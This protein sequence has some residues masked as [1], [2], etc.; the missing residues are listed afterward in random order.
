MSSITK[1]P[2]SGASP[3]LR[4]G[5]T[6]APSGDWQDEYLARLR[7]VIM[8]ADPAIVEEWK[9]KKPSNPEGV[10]VWYHDGIV[11]VGNTLKNAVRLTFPNGPEL[12]DPAKLFNTRLDSKVVRA[13]D[14]FEDAKLN[15][16]ALR[17]LVRAAVR[18]NASLVR[19]REA[20]SKASKG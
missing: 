13:I 7:G 11:C 1:R 4:K 15:K 9:W 6:T 3:P 8:S 19:Q 14:F 17:T 5:S 2:K 12:P 10:P 16:P 18:M 20:R